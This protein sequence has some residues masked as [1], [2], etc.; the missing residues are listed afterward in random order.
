[1]VAPFECGP[2]PTIETV[3]NI[4]DA[5]REEVVVAII[6]HRLDLVPP[7]ADQAP[8]LDRGF[9]PH[10]EPA[11]P[12]STDLEFRNGVLWLQSDRVNGTG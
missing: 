2:L 7:L 6:K 11:K 10:E 3:F 5:L 12:L 8:I 4:T 1:M 9:M